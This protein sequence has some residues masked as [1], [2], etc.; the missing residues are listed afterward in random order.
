[1][2]DVSAKETIFF[3]QAENGIR[4]KL[5]TGVQTCALPISPIRLVPIVRSA[6]AITGITTPHGWTVR[7]MR[8]SLII[9]PQSARGGWSPKPRKL[10]AAISPRS[11]ERRVGKECRPRGDAEG[12]VVCGVQK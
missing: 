6:I 9:R 2:S 11:E 1:M 7:A 5:V 12:G 8:F 10:S 3:S 4:D